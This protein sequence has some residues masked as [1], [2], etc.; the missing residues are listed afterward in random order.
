M[1]KITEADL[2]AGYSVCSMC[3]FK[4]ASVH[5]R[6]KMKQSWPPIDRVA[7]LKIICMGCSYVTLVKPSTIKLTGLYI[8]AGT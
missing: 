2:Q 4:K 1:K 5:A 7:H 6:E 8:G 3:G